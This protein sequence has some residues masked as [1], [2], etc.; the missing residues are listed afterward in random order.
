MPAKLREPPAKCQ[1]G[2]IISYEGRP[3]EVKRQVIYGMQGAKLLLEDIGT[4]LERIVSYEKIQ[5]PTATLA[6]A[7][8]KS[9]V[10]HVPV[11]VECLLAESRALRAT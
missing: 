4:G 9:S 2:A 7:A 6:R 1:P 3:Y 11:S 8:P 5:G 10:E